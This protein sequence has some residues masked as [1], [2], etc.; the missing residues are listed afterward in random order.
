VVWLGFCCSGGEIFLYDISSGETTQITD[1]INVDS[2]PRIANGRVVWTS[3]EVTNSVQPG[4]IFLYNIAAQETQRLTNNTSDDSFPRI[5]DESVIWVGA[6]VEEPIEPGPPPWSTDDSDDDDGLC[7]IA[8]AAFGSYMD[9]HV[10][11]IKDFRDEHLL[12][13]MPGRWFVSMYNTYGPFW[14]DL[15]NAHPWC[16]P[17]VRLALTPLVGMSYFVV[18]ASLATK[19]LTGFLLMGFIVIC[20]LRT[21]GSS[22]T[23]GHDLVI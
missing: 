16:K 14:A 1:D 21:H 5:N 11:I 17:F 18:K 13:N 10:Q 8:T 20:V 4:E 9:P 19:L 22:V 23:R 6:D 12:T 7:F 3:C 15:L 2:P